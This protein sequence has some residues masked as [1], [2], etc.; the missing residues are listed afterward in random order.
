MP[1][2]K[3]SALRAVFRFAL[4]FSVLVAPWPWLGEAM[5]LTFC[6]VAS[7]VVEAFVD[8][9]DA[10]VR[11]EP[12][13][14][15]SVVEPAEKDWT[16]NLSVVRT[17]SDVRSEFPLGLR[18]MAYYP[19][20]VFVALVFAAPIA[21][22]RRRAILLGGLAVLAA[23]LVLAVALPLCSFFGAFERGKTADR[24]AQT[25]FRSFIEP[26]NMVYAIPVVLLLLGLLLTTEHASRLAA[27]LSSRRSF[28]RER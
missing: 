19:F 22:H 2:A 8:P 11:F 15:S 7:P 17:G 5:T 10:S 1:A 24:I 3:V 14:P 28:G 9:S 13:Q 27:P 6:I 26:P 23:R 25:I 20:A 4:I 12:A 18:L 21:A 16:V